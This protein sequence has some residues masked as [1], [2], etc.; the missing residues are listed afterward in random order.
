MPNGEQPRRGPIP[1]SAVIKKTLSGIVKAQED[2]E[3]WSGGVCWL[4]EAPEYMLTTYIAKEIWTIPGSKYLILEPSVRY[5]VGEAGGFGRGRLYNGTRPDG[6]SD[7]TLWWGSG[8]PWAGGTPRAVIEVKNQI[9]TV[10][11][12]KRDINR[13][14]SMLKNRDNSLQF[15]LIAFYTNR[16]DRKGDG[17]QAKSTIEGW[18]KRIK[19]GTRNILGT[20]YHLSR[21]DTAI[22]VDGDSAWVGSVLNIRRA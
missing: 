12:I 1:I 9:S 22:T 21:H 17:K 14:K 13:I 11:E 4:W 7:I 20:G 6:R 18:L 15:G 5:T 3:A 2:Y 16:K 8:T 10:K 19:C